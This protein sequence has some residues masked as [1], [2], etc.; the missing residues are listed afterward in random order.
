VAACWPGAGPAHQARPPAGVL[1][2]LA[3]LGQAHE[4][5]A[6]DGL[7]VGCKPVVDAFGGL[8]ERLAHPAGGGVAG[9][10]EIAPLAAAPGFQQGVREQRQGARL[11]ADLL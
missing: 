8:G 3:Q 11:L 10:G 2:A 4:D 5:G 6:G 7:F 1:G 9:Q